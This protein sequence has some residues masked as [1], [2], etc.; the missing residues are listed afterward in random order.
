[1][2]MS[3]AVE[4]AV[5]A[6]QWVADIKSNLKRGG[7]WMEGSDEEETESDDEVIKPSR[8]IGEEVYE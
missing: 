1:M 2:T 5:E 7:Y 8:V 3:F 4:S 6:A